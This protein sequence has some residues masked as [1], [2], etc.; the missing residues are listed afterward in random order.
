ML[1]ASTASSKD[2]YRLVIEQSYI[3][4]ED[5]VHFLEADGPELKELT[6]SQLVLKSFK[7]I[8]EP[9]FQ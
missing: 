7:L 2:L 1:P 4:L 8:T 9:A 3:N 6:S 5:L